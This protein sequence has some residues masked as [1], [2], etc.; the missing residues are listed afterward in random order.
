MTQ[1]QVVVPITPATVTPPSAV[2][3]AQNPV[4][5][6]TA[7]KSG[8]SSAKTR[9]AARGFPAS[10]RRGHH[11]AEVGETK[12]FG[13]TQ[14]ALHNLFPNENVGLEMVNNGIAVTGLVNDPETAHRIV[15]VV[16]QYVP[17]GAHVVNMMQIKTNQQVMLRV[18]IGEIKR[19]AAKGF[20]L[21]TLNALEHDGLFKTLAEPNLVAISGETANFLSGGEFPVPVSSDQGTTVQ[22]KNYGIGL[23]FTPIV[24]SQNRIR[25]TV[26]S[27]VSDLSSKGEVKTE[28]FSIPSLTERKARTTVELAPGESYM[29]AGLLKDNMTVKTGN[30]SGLGDIPVLGA[31]FRDSDIDRN[32]TELVIAVTPYLVDPVKARDIRLPS[33]DYHTPSQM[34]TILFGAL[35]S[36]DDTDKVQLQNPKAA[37]PGGFGF[38]TE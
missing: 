35:G 1:S 13:E 3:K 26:E 25:L 37:V 8:K 15:E 14:L 9:A 19:T 17:K 36:M 33:D 2:A 18:R 7:K 30:I 28:G 10:M 22:Y 6:K 20:G 24:L 23:Q 11:P 31:L 34:E 29:I 4:K 38:M 32:E 5:K 21:L 12:N 27:E 16:A